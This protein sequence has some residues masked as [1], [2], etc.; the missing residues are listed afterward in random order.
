MTRRP[1]LTA[2]VGGVAAGT[3]SIAGATIHDASLGTPADLRAV[4]LTAIQV[5]KA[6]VE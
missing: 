4:E 6:N 5:D 1:L 3:V 2:V